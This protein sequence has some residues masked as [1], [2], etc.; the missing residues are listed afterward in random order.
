MKNNRASEYGSAKVWRY[1]NLIKFLDIL[2]NKR[3]LLTR[4]DLLGDQC[5]GSL[6]NGRDEKQET[7]S[8]EACALRELWEKART[9]I[10]VNCWYMADKECS[11]MWKL[12]S[13]ASVGIALQSTYGK[14]NTAVCSKG[15]YKIHPVQYL[16]YTTD[17]LPGTE[18]WRPSLC[19]RIEYEDE[20][21]VRIIFCD[22]SR[23]RKISNDV[24]PVF[25]EGPKNMEIHIEPEAFID[26]VYIYPEH[27]PSSVGIIQAI[28]LKYSPGLNIR[29]SSLVRPPNYF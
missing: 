27:E 4:I 25:V 5:E 9:I 2:V 17:R 26:N 12:Y 23:I 14:L 18:L 29:T 15:N 16:N 10:Y 22:L 20:R 13:G 3:I 24:V 6:P 19:K 8:R 21:E 11:A 1:I 28:V 7:T